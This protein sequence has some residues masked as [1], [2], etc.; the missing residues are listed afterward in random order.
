MGP[1]RVQSSRPSVGETESFDTATLNVIVIGTTSQDTDPKNPNP[2]STLRTYRIA[3]GMG[4]RRGQRA[5]DPPVRA[6]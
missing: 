5:R 2:W 4:S 1:L 6:R 3:P